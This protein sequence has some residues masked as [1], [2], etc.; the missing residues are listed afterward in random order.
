MSNITVWFIKC[1]LVYLLL[2]MFIGIY[3]T[4]EGPLY[5]Y[6]PIH[7]HLNMLGWMSMMIYG[8][9]YH[10]LPRFSGQPLWSEKLANAHLWLAN[11]GLVGMLGGWV[12]SE[13]R[14][15]LGVLHLFS[16]IEALSIVF[17]ITNMFKTVKAAPQ[18]IKK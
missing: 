9:S 14:G 15:G 6:K 13:A 4:V 17:F 11:I 7:T 2:A 10:I 3:M 1:A 16:L 18:P 8:V 5:P 12:M